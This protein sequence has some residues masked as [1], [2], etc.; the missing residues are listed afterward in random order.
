MTSRWEG[1]PMCAL[2][3]LA[4]GTPIVSTPTD[5]LCEL[6]VDG[7]N[8]F[9][10]DEDT[11]LAQRIFELVSCEQKRIKMSNCAREKA[12]EQNK[13]KVYKASIFDVYRS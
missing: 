2:E 1:T 8:G 12:Q 5:G 7:E 11:M 6:I 4:L 10:S 13:K 3:S 9:I